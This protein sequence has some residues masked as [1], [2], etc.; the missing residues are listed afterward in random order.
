M[1]KT[2]TTTIKCNSINDNDKKHKIQRDNKKCYCLLKNAYEE[3][4]IFWDIWKT[5]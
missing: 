4:N 5:K 3:L 1:I 2:T